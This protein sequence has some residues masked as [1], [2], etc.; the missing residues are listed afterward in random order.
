MT[1]SHLVAALYAGRVTYRA[2]AEG[3]LHVEAPAAALTLDLRQAMRE[4][5][6]DLL[7]LCSGGVTIYGRGAEPA[8]WTAAAPETAAL[9]E[10]A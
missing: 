7:F 8:E 10:V 5:R 2:T 1:F 6:N 4:H 3:K 9:V